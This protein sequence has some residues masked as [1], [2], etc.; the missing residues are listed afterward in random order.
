MPVRWS[1]GRPAQQLCFEVGDAFIEEAV[2][3]PGS[4]QAFVQGAVVGGQVP[5]ALFEG[6]VLGGKPLDGVADAGALG[7][8]LSVGGFEGLLGVQRPLLPGCFRLGVVVGLVLAAVT[9]SWA[10]GLS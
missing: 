6:R 3:G 5:D 7:A 1:A 10:G 8:D 2:V 9:R 4:L